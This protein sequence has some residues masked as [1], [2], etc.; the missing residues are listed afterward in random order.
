VVPVARLLED[1][2]VAR[3]SPA[4]VVAWFAVRPILFPPV[5]SPLRCPASVPGPRPVPHRTR[6]CKRPKSQSR[7]RPCRRDSVSLPRARSA[8]SAC[9]RSRVS[10]SARAGSLKLNLFCRYQPNSPYMSWSGCSCKNCPA[11]WPANP[12]RGQ[13]YIHGS[14]LHGLNWLCG[15][16]ASLSRPSCASAPAELVQQESRQPRGLSA[17][18][19][20]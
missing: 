6:S 11:C 17:Q 20:K 14:K 4:S 7:Y 18:Q 1:L 13:R 5:R 12:T 19:R 16:R 9:W 2:P 3:S 10:A 15:C 8:P